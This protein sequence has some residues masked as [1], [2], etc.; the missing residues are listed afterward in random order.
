MYLNKK[1]YWLEILLHILLWTAITY[2]L[3]SLSIT[4]F[5][6]RSDMR[7]G[8]NSIVMEQ[9]IVKTF[10]PLCLITTGFLMVLFYSTVFWLINKV[11]L[12]KKAYLSILVVVAWFAIIFFLN[13]F[14]IGLFWDTSDPKIPGIAKMHL[15]NFGRANWLHMQLTILTIF[16]FTFG[17]A[18]AYFFAKA[19]IRNE[20]I[21]KQLEANQLSTEIKFLKSQINPH[22]LFNTLNNLFSMAQGKGNEELADGISRLSE[23]MRYM[24]Y[25]SNTEQV[26]LRKEIEYLESYILLNKLRYPDDE[27][28]VN[29]NYPEQIDSLFIA[30]MLFIPFAENAFKHGVMIGKPWEV[31]MGVNL[32]D[33]QVVFWCKNKNYSYVKKM[34]DKTRGI[35]LKNVKR[36]LELLYPNNYDLTINSDD[37]NYAVELKINLT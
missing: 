5:K 15:P 24:L 7:S 13:Y 36:R 35:G 19:W 33:K 34:D 23:M 16:L 4:A 29:F 11:M 1:K 2:V 18:I 28:K 30:P 12:Y 8:H 25:E 14:I 37:E 27:V 20:I 26:A 31:D 32:F 6:I 9:T 3:G 17:L 21:R 22:F 10:F